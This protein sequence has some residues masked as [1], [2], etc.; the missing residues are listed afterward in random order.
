MVL[1]PSDPL[2]ARVP[3][4]SDSLRHM[5]CVEVGCL[6]DS[7]LAPLLVRRWVLTSSFAWHALSSCVWECYITA[8]S[9]LSHSHLF[10]WNAFRVNTWLSTKHIC[11]VPGLESELAG[12]GS[13]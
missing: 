2:T 4:G 7:W 8:L 10:L 11:Q 5:I 9:P 12:H 13:L 1:S 6:W 3:E